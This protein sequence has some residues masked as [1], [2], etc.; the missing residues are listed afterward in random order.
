MRIHLSI[1][2]LYQGIFHDQGRNV[3]YHLQQ[4]VLQLLLVLRYQR[5]PYLEAIKYR[6]IAYVFDG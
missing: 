6:N 5:G 2:K 1:P 4:D 3:K